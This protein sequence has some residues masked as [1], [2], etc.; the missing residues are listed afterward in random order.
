VLR[1]WQMV[2]FPVSSVASPA[3]LG[4]VVGDGVLR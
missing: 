3:W 4:G 2:F 1:W